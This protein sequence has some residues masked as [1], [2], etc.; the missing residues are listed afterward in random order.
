[1]RMNLP[2]RWALCGSALAV[3]AAG[4][5][6]GVGASP[7]PDATLTAADAVNNDLLGVS[8]AV[9]GDTAVAGAN[10]KNS[11]QGAAYVFTRTGTTWSQQAMLLGTDSVPGDGFGVVAISG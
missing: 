8:V 6:F 7:A 10:G 11:F 3:L 4:I 5:A 2:K 1:M 9:A